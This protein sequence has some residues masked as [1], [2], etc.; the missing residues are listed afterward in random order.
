MTEADDISPDRRALVYRHHE[1]LYRLALLATG[2]ADAAAALVE[3]AYRALP[4]NAPDAEAALIRA[5]I[6]PGRRERARRR[7]SQR[8]EV[9][10]GA[11]DRVHAEQ[12]LDQI[13]ALPHAERLVVGLHYLRGLSAG[14]IAELLGAAAGPRSPADILARFRVAVA[15]AFA[16]VPAGADDALLLDLDRSMDGLLDAEQ[17]QA[18]RWSAF[19]RADTRGLRDALIELRDRLPRAIPA[20]FAATPPLDLTERLLED[21]AAAP[22]LARGPRRLTRAHGALALGVLALVAAIVFSPSLLPR[23]SQPVPPPP[24]PS[25][26]IEA[27]IHRFDRAPVQQGVLH[28]QYRVQAGRTAYL[29]ERWYDYST[30]QRLRTTITAEG[31]KDAPLMEISSDG[32]SLIQYRFGPG[33]QSSTQRSVDVQVS[34]SEA[35]KLLPLLRSEPSP[36]FFS[37]SVI[38]QIDLTPR[39]LAQARAANA[40]FLGTT[41]YLNRPAYLLTY[42]SDQPPTALPR[43]QG[44]TPQQVVLTIDA[45]TYA[46]L[47]VAL[48]AQGEAESAARHPLQAQALELSPRLPEGGFTLPETSDVVQQNDVQSVHFPELPDTQIISLDELLRR[49][50]GALLA[51][52]QLPD[53]NMRGQVLAVDPSD[54]SRA[55]L[56]YE[57]EFQSV[58]LL[59]QRM[60]SDSGQTLRQE[61]SAGDFRYRIVENFGPGPNLVAQVYRPDTPDNAMTVMLVDE[62]ATAQ[63]REATLQRLIASLTPLTAQTLPALRSSFD[64]LDAAGG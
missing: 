63:E 49:A 14:E 6:A 26:I 24:A 61:Q 57:G 29:I 21:L 19:E 1:Q 27:A 36:W 17:A 10:G 41:S 4:A 13:A 16:L 23:R 45:Q 47:D 42:R 30:P 58:L 33:L 64:H 5:L 32:R 62:Y 40:T 9:R 48:L 22:R 25:E 60:F 15:H 59:P 8:A 37:R 38:N 55:L 54:P 39:Y 11:L 44:A 3:R 50:P 46:L 12:L 56:L 31:S 34:Q 53:A 7:R 43:R 35:Q 20:L 18:L 52:Q 28:E 51:P 2:D